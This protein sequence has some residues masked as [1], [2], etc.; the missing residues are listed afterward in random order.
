VRSFAAAAVVLASLAS[1]RPARA[2][3]TNCQVVNV[4]PIVFGNYVAGQAHPVDAVGELDVTCNAN[5]TIQ[6][7]FSRGL[8][9]RLNPRT[10]TTPLGGSLAYNIFEDAAG[11][12]VWGDGTGGSRIYSA[13]ALMGQPLRLP[14]FGRIYPLQGTPP[15]VYHD[16]VQIL[17]VF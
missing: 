8:S 3:G 17:V 15:G 4:V 13:M 12:T 1:V 2:A 14:V 6:V 16:T 10:M 11:T 7:T 9:S 5:L